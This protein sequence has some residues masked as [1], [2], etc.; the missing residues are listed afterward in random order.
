MLINLSKRSTQPELMDDFQDTLEKLRLVFA[1]INRVNT[2]LGGSSITINAVAKLMQSQ[3]K[4]L[5]TVVDMGC[6][7]GYMLRKLSSYCEKRKI[8]VRLIGIDLNEQALEIA[9]ELSK[10]ND[11]IEYYHQ[12]I[13]ALKSTDFNCD[14]IMNT[15][16]MHHFEEADLIAFLKKFNELAGIG[17][18]I[19]DLHRSSWAYCLF[20]L[21]SLIFIQTQTAKIDGLISISKGFFKSDLLKYSKSLPDS[22]HRITWRWA[23][24]Y[25]WVMTPNL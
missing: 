23:F 3:T 5:Y 18:V 14:I 8:K 4:D 7:D 2:I 12:D 6:G 25:L 11:N 19:N 1:D 22:T 24:R 20:K 17:V 21:F 9:K 15:L 16:T 10:N 13:L